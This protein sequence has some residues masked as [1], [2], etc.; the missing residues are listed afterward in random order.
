MGEYATYQGRSVKIGTCEDMLY[1]RYGQRDLVSPEP[2]SGIREERDRFRFPFPDEDRVEPGAFTN[3]FRSLR[4][5]GVRAPEGVEHDK[6]QFV[7]SQ[8][9]YVCS[10]PCP[11]AL[12]DGESGLTAGTLDLADGRWLTINRNGFRGSVLLC[13]QAVRDGVLAAVCECGG[14]GR[15]FWLGYPQ[16]LDAFDALMA[17]AERGEREM[18]LSSYGFTEADIES[19][20]RF[21]R[22][23]AVR[24]LEG[25]RTAVPTAEVAR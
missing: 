23:T 12:S 4:L 10:L 17:R 19:A 16:A 14:C 8:S 18:R 25:Y 21:Y 13:Q 6:V 20:T 2:G 15:K 1:L 22:V 24:L 3:P 5:D 11:E 9:G 7:A